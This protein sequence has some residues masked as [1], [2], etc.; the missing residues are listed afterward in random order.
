MACASLKASAWFHSLTLTSMKNKETEAFAWMLQR[1]CEKYSCC[2]H[3]RDAGERV[4]VLAD[5]PDFGVQPQASCAS[6]SPCFDLV[7]V[8]SAACAFGSSFTWD[9][10]FG[11]FPCSSIISGIWD[12]DRVQLL[13]SLAAASRTAQALL[14]HCVAE[15]GLRSGQGDAAHAQA[16]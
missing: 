1:K 14:E 15:G 8:L 9:G 12:S 16:R 13:A 10:G 11:S 5:Q 4:F 3:R 2:R 6:S 7:M